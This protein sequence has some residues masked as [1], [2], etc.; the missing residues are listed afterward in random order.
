M[1]MFSLVF[2]HVALKNLMQAFSS[3]SCALDDRCSR[4]R[5][6]LLD[7]LA[8]CGSGRIGFSPRT[9]YS[10]LS[11][12]AVTKPPVNK[13]SL[14]V[15][16]CAV[17]LNQVPQQISFYGIYVFARSGTTIFL[18]FFSSFSAETLYMHICYLDDISSN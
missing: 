8:G 16:I 1:T 12:V 13:L 5:R 18:G 4:T 17:F 11:E 3:S 15:R 14:C 7:T 10:C 6:F 2:G 9:C